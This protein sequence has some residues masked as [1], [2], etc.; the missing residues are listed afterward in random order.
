MDL[1]RLVATRRASWE[2]LRVLTRQRH[3]TGEEA[4]E[5][6]DLYGQAATDLSTIRSAAPDPTLVA[7]LSTLV[8]RARGRTTGTRRLST[9]DVSRYFLVT[10]PVVVYRA[11]WWVV[12]VSCAFVVVAFAVGY[13]IT[14]N[15]D[16]QPAIAAPDQAQQLVDEDFESYYSSAP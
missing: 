11:R 5:F 14:D 4:D 9:A 10:F 15:P 16:V 13:Y 12:A 2:R 3:L 1:D 7:E 6:V 8:S